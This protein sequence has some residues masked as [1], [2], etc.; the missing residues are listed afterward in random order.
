MTNL[1]LFIDSSTIEKISSLGL[2]S[3]IASMAL[4]P[5]YTTLAFRQK[6]WKKPRTHT[7]TGEIAKV[8]HKLHASKH[9]R[10]IPTMAGA[11]FV[12]STL[13]V[14][15]SGNLSRSETWLP[16]AAMTGAG[17]IGLFD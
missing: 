2:L 16:L 7:M 5:I 10:N 4:T 17:L 3:F 11:I 6:W 14:T 9:E 13:L 15:L 8:Y 12:L 1:L